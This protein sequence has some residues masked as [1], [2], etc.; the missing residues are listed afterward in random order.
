MKF[1]IVIPAYNE[2]A[3]LP[4]AL[5]TLI[6]GID[7]LSE[8][9]IIVSDGGSSDDSCEQAARF[10]GRFYPFADVDSFWSPTFRQPGAADRL[11]GI[12]ERWP[13]VGF[14]HYLS[15]EEDGSWLYENE[16]SFRLEREQARLYSEFGFGKGYVAHVGVRQIDYD[17]GLDNF[18]DFRADIAEL[19]VGYRWR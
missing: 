15:G 5:K 16:G 13:I 7:Y 3:A 4:F 19:A 17:E 11:R 10:P 2:S 12:A 1:S 18:D 8:V 6:D 9:E 14:T